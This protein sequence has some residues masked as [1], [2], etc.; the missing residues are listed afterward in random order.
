[1]GVMNALFAFAQFI[2]SPIIGRISDRIGRKPIILLGL[3]LFT[4][5]EY[6]FAITNQL[7][8]LMFQN[9]RGI[10]AAMIVPTEMALAADITTK[11]I[12]RA[13]GWLSAAFSGGLI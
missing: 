9:H 2:A 1:M 13:I 8:V 3:F 4:V 11:S 5:S 10:S 7:L 12:V 6:L